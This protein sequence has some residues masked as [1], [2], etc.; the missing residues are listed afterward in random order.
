MSNTVPKAYVDCAIY[1]EIAI[2]SVLP[3]LLPVKTLNL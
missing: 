2:Q 1:R 3:I